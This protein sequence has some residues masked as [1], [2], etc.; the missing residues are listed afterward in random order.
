MFGA[1]YRNDT[2]PGGVIAE[3]VRDCPDRTRV[4][5]CVRVVEKMLISKFSGITLLTL[6]ARIAL[7]PLRTWWT[8]WTRW[9]GRSCRTSRAYDA[10]AIDDYSACSSGINDRN[11]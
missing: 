10:S 2:H 11:R 9:T 6:L 8:F 3:V 4:G 5:L 7:W 1:I